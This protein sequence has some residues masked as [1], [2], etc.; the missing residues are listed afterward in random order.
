WG[1]VAGALPGVNGTIAIGVTI[2]LTFGMDPINVV[3]FMV[4]I[5][6]GVAYGN[7][8]PAILVGLPGTPAAV[9]TAMDGFAL[10]KRGKSGLA[11]GTMYFAAVTGQ[12][13]SVF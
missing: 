7:S 4:A 3:A 8:I 10:H 11:L 1:S 5:N 13:I 2:P 6:V 9:L 12:F